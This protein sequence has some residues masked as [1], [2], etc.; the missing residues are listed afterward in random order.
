MTVISI[1]LLISWHIIP[2]LTLF[3][4]HTYSHHGS[5]KTQM[6]VLWFPQQSL[7]G[8]LTQIWPIKCRSLA[9]SVWTEKQE[10]VTAAGAVAAGGNI[11]CF[12]QCG[13]NEGPG[14]AKA[15]VCLPEFGSVVQSWP[16]LSLP[17]LPLSQLTSQGLF[18][19]PPGNS[20]SNSIVSQ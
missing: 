2:I 3:T 19:S 4:A 9:F 8:L 1:F 11:Q 7:H 18:S 10:P 13:E 12:W 6:L 17:G 16:W 14:P 15:A 5:H 20:G